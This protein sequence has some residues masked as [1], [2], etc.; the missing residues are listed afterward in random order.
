MLKLA[1]GGRNQGNRELLL[2]FIFI[3]SLLEQFELSKLAIH[4]I[5][6]LSQLFFCVFFCLSFAFYFSKVYCHLSFS[7]ISSPILIVPVGL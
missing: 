2:F 4:K 6:F 1:C 7:V 3:I 5:T